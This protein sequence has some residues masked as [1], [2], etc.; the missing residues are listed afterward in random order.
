MI[1]LP[2]Q[3]A[4][5]YLL[6]LSSGGDKVTEAARGSDLKV[7]VSC[8]AYRM[9]SLSFSK[10]SQNHIGAIWYFIHDYNSRLACN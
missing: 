5:S 1:V 3:V 9:K 4:K 2:A 8:R 10:N 6:S 7:V